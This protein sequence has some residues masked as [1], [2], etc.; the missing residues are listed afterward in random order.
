[1]RVVKLAQPG[2]DVKTA[3]DENLIYSSLWPLLRIYKQGSFTI[4]DV[5][6][7]VTIAEHDLPFTPM[8]WFFSNSTINGWQ[9]TGAVINEQRS[10]FFGPQA[11]GSIVITDSALKFQTGG[12][13]TGSLQIYY[14][15][16]ALDLLQRFTAPIIKVGNVGGGGDESR[17]FKIA[18]PGKDIHSH[19][20][21]DF[22]IHSRARSPLV[23]SVTPGTVQ[24][25]EFTVF[26]N[27]GYNPMFFGYS[28][29]SDGSYE[30]LPT[31]S[32]G[33]NSFVTDDNK[34]KFS[35]SSS[36]ELSI[37]IL[38]DPFLIEQSVSVS[39]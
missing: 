37:V 19:N 8:Y 39:I 2:Y 25:G 10:E 21:E 28:K 36:R 29:N 15:I 22:V 4:S 31:G 6:Q 11:N 12:G 5:T 7:N 24:S 1:M 16:F 32:G 33:S 20:L 30:L 27:L 3:G 14:Y 18:K 13:T 9:N 35:E 17:V 38:K 26:H 23:H 34:V